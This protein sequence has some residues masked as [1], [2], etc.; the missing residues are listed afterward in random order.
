MPVAPY[1]VYRQSPRRR[2]LYIVLAAACAGAALIAWQLLA[3][4][5]VSAVTPGPGVY[6]KVPAQTVSL[7]VHGLQRL[8]DLRVALDG[9]D[10]TAATTLRGDKLVFTTGELRDGHHTV[11]FSARS[12]NLFRRHVSERWRFTVDTVVPALKLSRKAADGRLNGAPATF[13][14]TT[15]A[16]ATVTVASGSV[17]ATGQAD[18]RGNYAVSAMLPDGPSSV[19]VTTTD[20]AGN[21]A[22]QQVDVFV[23]SVPPL[24][25]TTQLAR[26]VR[27]ANLKIRVRAT[28][29]IGTPTVRV[30]LDGNPLPRSGPTADATVRLK[31]LAEGTH[32]LRVSASDRGGNIV[33]EKQT[34]VVDSTE[35]FG[36]A[37]LWPGARGKDVKELQRRLAKAGLYS[38]RATG[39]YDRAT[40]SGVRKFQAKYAMAVDGLVGDSVLAAISGQIVVDLSD[41]RLYLYHNGHLVKSY[42]VATG[43]PA[44]PT[45][46]GSYSIVS[47][48]KDPTWLPP[49]SDWAKDAKPIPPGTENPLGTRWMGT[50]APGVGLH[51]VPPSEDSSIGTYASH[52]CVRM[53][54]WDAIDLFDRIVVG[55]PVLI[56]P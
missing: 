39:V 11:S 28:D 8:D 51:G 32:V 49:N 9:R 40:T 54:N 13:D 23:D 7:D 26:T 19:T 56:R 6:V 34:F 44:W 25:R 3:A 42:S 27:R 18:S 29:Q 43:Q 31:G 33:A 12:S 38:G 36:A 4:P 52:G 48:Q 37:T 45:P 16:F 53:H 35:E 14:G 10:I 5:R 46:T 1:T 15:E 50:S 2:W 21:S 20:R 55:M 22:Q 17:E 41:L 30:T 47:M 24:L